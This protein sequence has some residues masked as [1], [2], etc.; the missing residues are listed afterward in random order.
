MKIYIWQHAQ[1]TTCPSLI[2]RSAL[3]RSEPKEQE[4]TARSQSSAETTRRT[5]SWQ[6]KA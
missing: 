3:D 5:P 2:L 6:S 1:H 4:T